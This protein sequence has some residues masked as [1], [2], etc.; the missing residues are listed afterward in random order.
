MILK[1]RKLKKNIQVPKCAKPTNSKTRK[2]LF[3]LIKEVNFV[4]FLDLFAG[5]G[6][7]GIESAFEG[8]KEITFVDK[9]IKSIK[10][11]NK[12]IKQCNLDESIQIKVIN[13]SHS[14]FIKNSTK[15]YDIVFVDPPYEMVEFLELN[16]FTK[17]MNKRSILVLQIPT[18]KSILLINKIKESN[19]Y[20][21]ILQKKIGSTSLIFLKLNYL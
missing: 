2:I 4:S 7:V 20:E 6:V 1:T 10:C 16:N 12:N 18:K 15:T 17:L 8:A 9:N 13:K 21:I 3:D 19:K 11:I 5:S 14:Q